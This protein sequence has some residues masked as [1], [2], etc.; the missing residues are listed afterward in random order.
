MA[1]RGI[2]AA[3]IS[4]VFAL[5]LV[6]AGYPEAAD[7]VPVTFLTVLLTVLFYGLAAGPL[8]NRLGLVQSNPQGMLF[9]GAD[10]WVRALAHALQEEGCAVFLVDTHWENVRSSQM[11]GLPC[12]HGSALAEATR[13]EIN[14]AGLGRMLA[15]TSNNE[16][17]SLACLRYAEDFGRKAVYQL[18]FATIK[19]G[20]HEAVSQ[21]HRGR[22]LFGRELDFAAI[23]ELAGADPKVKKTGLTAEFD[24]EAF[25]A[26][27]GDTVV[28]LFVL[29]ADGSV[30]IR[31]VGE[32][33]VPKAGDKVVSLVRGGSCA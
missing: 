20:R 6:E 5:H 8:G 4:S 26:E 2:V 10:A 25:E 19:D 7:I 28:P 30:Y 12:L 17:N 29:R 13:E 21:V 15:V 22:L 16:V 27:H 24:Y 32:W 3:A 14:Y 33:P 18:P 11:M 23:S 31:T 9:V 1:P